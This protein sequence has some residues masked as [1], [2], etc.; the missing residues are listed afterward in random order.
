MT[1]RFCVSRKNDVEVI[2]GKEPQ[3]DFA[4][5]TERSRRAEYD[6]ALRERTAIADGKHTSALAEKMTLKLF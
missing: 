1:D 2:L 5:E 4:D 6:S 3:I